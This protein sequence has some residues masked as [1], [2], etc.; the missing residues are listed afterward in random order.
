MEFPA[1]SLDHVLAGSTGYSFPSEVVDISQLLAD[2]ADERD[3]VVLIDLREGATGYDAYFGFEILPQCR[4][5]RIT[6]MGRESFL[7]LYSGID[8]GPVVV[9]EFETLRA[10]AVFIHCGS[11]FRVQRSR[12]FLMRRVATPHG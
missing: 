12:R 10:L 1:A 8:A 3:S 11:S 2:R 4:V 5:L 6:A 7:R 9:F